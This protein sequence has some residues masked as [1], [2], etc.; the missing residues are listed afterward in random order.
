MVAKGIEFT[1][2][3]YR[4]WYKLASS[5]RRPTRALPLPTTRKLFLFRGICSLRVIWCALFQ[6]QVSPA[7]EHLAK[8]ATGCQRCPLY[9]FLASLWLHSRLAKRLRAIRS[10]QAGPEAGRGHLNLGIRLPRLNSNQ[11]AQER[12]RGGLQIAEKSCQM[13]PQSIVSRCLRDSLCCR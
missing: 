7:A 13:T 5:S 9:N 6:Q 2:K 8:A 1:L 3:N 11:G 4:A 10:H 12:V